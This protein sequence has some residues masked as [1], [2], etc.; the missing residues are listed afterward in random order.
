METTIST[1]TIDDL[2]DEHLEAAEQYLGHHRLPVTFCNPNSK[3]PTGKGWPKRT[4]TAD[5][6]A[7]EFQK[8]AASGSCNP[9]VVLGT[10]SK[11]IDIEIDGADGEREFAELCRGCRT[12]PVTPCYQSKKGRHRFF[13]WS[14]A[15]AKLPQNI[16]LGSIEIRLGGQSVLPPGT[17]DGFERF[18]LVPLDECD[19]QPLPRSIIQRIKQAACAPRASRCRSLADSNAS[20]SSNLATSSPNLTDYTNTGHV[21]LSCV[22]DP[23]TLDK[24][25]RQTVVREFRTRHPK[26]FQFARCLK[27][28][29]EYADRD[30]ESL[31]Q[32]V[33]EWFQRG[34]PFINK[35]TSHDEN[36][37]DFCEGWR[38]IRYAVGRSNLDS[39]FQES[40]TEPLSPQ[41][42]SYFEP[43]DDGILALVRLCKVQA[44][45]AAPDPFSSPC[46]TVVV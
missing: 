40:L 22:S 5:A 41:I 14:R 17:S 25:Y 8:H 4:W 33:G 45:R 21:L 7:G 27:S 39:A 9:G 42:E 15:F 20:E 37:Q 29:P 32:I 11:I 31:E 36:F 1:T 43:D 24:A 2:D 12:M 18:W 35:K 26:V 16:K 38:K 46:E 3:V 28:M 44:R 34:R 19:P 23:M 10:R 6:V 13:K 30:P